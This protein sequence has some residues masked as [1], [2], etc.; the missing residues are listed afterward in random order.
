MDITI[1]PGRLRGNLTAIPSKSQAHRM[2]ICAA[3]AERETTIHC[4]QVNK[5]IEATVLCLNA[6]G[7]VIN[8]TSYG[9]HVTP[10]SAI[11]D[12]AVLHCG[13]SGSTLRFLLPVAGALGIDTTFIMDGRLPERPLSPLW[14]EMERMGC[15]LS[16]P[17]Y[18]KI[19]CTGKL[20]SGN[21]NISGNV[22][23]QFISGILFAS[24]LTSGKSSITINGKLES[25]PYITMTQQVLA[26][27]G[28]NSDNYQICGS[29][30]VKSPSVLTVEGDWSNAAFFLAANKL[31]ND[32][33]VEN[34]NSN[35]AQGDKAVVEC[36]ENLSHFTTID[37]SDI[38]DLIPILS[39]V[40]AASNGALFT[41]IQRLR[42]KESDRVNA[43]CELLNKFGI[44]TETTSQTLQVFPGKFSGCCIDSK[45]DHRIA[46]TAAIAA[47][48]AT[49]PVTITQAQCVEKSYPAFWD[50]YNKL[51]GKYE[52]HIR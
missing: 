11:P 41:N 3:F 6:F 42:L 32:V 33:T 21:W 50:V 29:K 13:E 43:I 8:R 24:A 18:N 1:T 15:S 40:A 51:G 30:P 20:T 26:T 49:G 10:V 7:A 34:L 38:P 39:V 16:R 28:V 14:E 17:A 31:G 37:A 4:E 12:K 47:T 19:R 52:Q 27:F 23:S 36:L 44:R 9:Y 5:D 35:S 45:N 46:M 48:I 25:R 2:L 22:S